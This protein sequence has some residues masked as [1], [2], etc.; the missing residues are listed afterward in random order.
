[1]S[2]EVELE[3]CKSN[4][5]WRLS[6][7]AILFRR[8]TTYLIFGLGLRSFSNSFPNGLLV[9]S[10]DHVTACERPLGEGSGYCSLSAR[11]HRYKPELQVLRWHLRWHLN[12]CCWP[13][14]TCARVASRCDQSPCQGRTPLTSCWCGTPL[15]TAFLLTP[16]RISVT[17]VKDVRESPSGYHAK[18]R[19]LI[20][21]DVPL[22]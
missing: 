9:K 16:P 2:Q 6:G 21:I 15:V 22:S 19:T 12:D 5:E 20:C 18:G 10:S 13:S 14:V 3:F 1:M 11:M 8:T 7:K 17:G 4:F